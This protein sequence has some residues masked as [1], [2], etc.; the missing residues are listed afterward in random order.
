LDILSTLVL[1]S[2]K[3]HYVD[4]RVLLPSG[5]GNA[6]SQLEW[7]FAGTSQSTPAERLGPGDA[8]SKPAHTVW[9]HWIDSDTLEEVK[10]EGDMRPQADGTVLETGTMT[11]LETG[12]EMTYEELWE[13]LEA[14]VVGR[15]KEK[16]C[17]VLRMEEPE[18]EARGYLIRI[19]EYIQGLVRSGDQVTAIRWQYSG[20][21]VSSHRESLAAC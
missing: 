15:E 1:T 5:E 13:D 20:E 12:G 14:N 18:K 11:N 2:P 10:D 9:S 19:G 6:F 8:I 21:E 16:I 7:A 4:V 3:K 17:L